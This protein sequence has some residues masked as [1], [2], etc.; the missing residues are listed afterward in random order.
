MNMPGLYVKRRQFHLPALGI[1]AAF[2]GFAHAEPPKVFYKKEGN[3]WFRVE[4][5]GDGKIL[6]AVRAKK[7]EPEGEVTASA[8]RPR[9]PKPPKPPKPVKFSPYVAYDVG[10]WPEAVAVGDLNNDGRT[11]VA[12]VTSYYFD[13]QNDNCLFV[14]LQDK[15]G[16]LILPAA[17][18]PIGESPSSVTVGDVNGD[19]RNDV[20]VG[21]NGDGISVLL[22]NSLGKLDAAVVTPTEHSLRVRI[23]NF[24]PDQHR[25]VAAIAWGSQ[26]PLVDVFSTT[27]SAALDLEQSV[28]GEHAGYDDLEVGDLNGDGLQD[29]LVMSGQSYAAPN[30]GVYLQKPDGLLEEP[31]FYELGPYDLTSGVGIG[32]LN[33]D[34]R[35]DI[36]ASYRGHSDAAIAIWHQQS[37]GSLGTP[38]SLPS[39]DSPEALEIGDLNKDGRA[40]IVV[41][42]GGSILGVYTQTA[43]GTLGDEQL[44]PVPYASSYNPHGLALGDINGDGFTDIVLADYNNGLVILKGTKKR[45]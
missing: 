11:D 23:G 13:E 35:N 40:E 5:D 37:D 8:R 45:R 25:A 24:G 16:R 39:H 31:E 10:S 4:K 43:T 14:F 19:G 41:A 20:V 17:K 22:Q 9:P 33:G 27:N 26:S 29:V 36:A 7:P 15:R 6:S 44:F 18:Y 12:L 42:H 32:D 38:F 2:I 1:L 3:S 28:E 30:I 34:G 21:R